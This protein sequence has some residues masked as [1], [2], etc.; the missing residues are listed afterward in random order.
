MRI[1]GGM[2][3]SDK[4]QRGEPRFPPEETLRR[5]RK[6][7]S[8]SKGSRTLPPG[9]DLLDKAKYALCR[10]F[11]EF[12]LKHALSQRE[13]AEILGVNE[14]RVSEIMHYHIH[15]LTLDRLVR[16]LEKIKPRAEVSVF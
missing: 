11:V 16:Y 12:A 3:G 15:K 5:M 9:A 1:G 2:A 13:L 10:Q 8:K 7:L 6:K 14:S 4:S